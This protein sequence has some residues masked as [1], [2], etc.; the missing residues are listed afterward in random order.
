VIHSDLCVNVP[1]FAGKFGVERMI[2][3]TGLNATV[4]RS[5]YHMN[6]EIT[7]RDVVTAHGIYP[8][9][10]GD[11]R[12]AMIAAI[13]LI[14]REQSSEPLPLNRINLVGPDTLTD[15]DAAAIWSN[16]LGRTIVFP[17]TTRPHSSRT[18]AGSS[19]QKGSRPSLLSLVHHAAANA[20]RKGAEAGREQT[21]LASRFL[22]PIC[23]A[24][25]RD[26]R[27]LTAV[28]WGVLGSAAAA[29]RR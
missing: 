13:E 10:I 16:V 12:F 14:R 27:M 28:A 4:L 23:T 17:A 9:P 7:V 26:R 11:K 19:I 29:C 1:H 2:G 18:C 6:D 5:A 25:H 22:W 21:S 8:M 20:G 15:A 24:F 3:A